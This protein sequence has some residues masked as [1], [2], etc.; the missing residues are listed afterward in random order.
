MY[1]KLIYWHPKN[2]GQVI[3]I[4]L[5]VE[6]FDGLTKCFLSVKVPK[7][8]LLA[9]SDRMDTDLTIAQMQGKF[10]LSVVNNTGHI[11]HEDDPSETYKIIDGFIKK[12]RIPARVQDIKPIIGKL[13]GVPNKIIKFDENN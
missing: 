13:G 8:L 12:F 6:W 11:I 1:G 7:I 10:K 3:N 9:A 4:I 2:I 5:F